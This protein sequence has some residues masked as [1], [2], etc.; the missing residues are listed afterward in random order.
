M[1]VSLIGTCVAG[2]FESLL[3][4]TGAFRKGTRSEKVGW[5]ETAEER[6]GAKIEKENRQVEVKGLLFYYFIILPFDVN[7]LI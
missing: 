2:A 7:V 4:Q 6:K 3:R 5:G 1:Y